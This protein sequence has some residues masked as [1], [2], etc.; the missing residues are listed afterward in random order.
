MKDS[1]IL[2]IGRVPSHWDVKRIAYLFH[3]RDERNHP[4]L[5]L[6][7]VS[8]HTGVTIRKFSD[9][10]IEQMAEDF[11]TYKVAYKGDI[12]FNK[13]RMWQGAVGIVPTD[14]LVS[15]DYVVAV[16][17]AEM[18]PAYYGY[19]FRTPAFSAETARHSH[20]I[21][22]DRLRLYW[23]GFHDIFVPVPSFD[24]QKKIVNYLGQQI[25]QLSNLSAKVETAIERL[26]EYRS[27][28]ISSAVTG[29]MDVRNH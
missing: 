28:L 21:V 15:P 26:R 4:E 18:D 10:H 20:G 19:L 1:G 7:N 8:I 6:L 3:E 23:D 13:M 27:A 22:W 25:N 11:S 16:P 14:G 29:K 9:E 2:W 17:S 24:E 5:P 12:S